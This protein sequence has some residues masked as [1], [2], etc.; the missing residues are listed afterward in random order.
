MMT[1]WLVLKIGLSSA[2]TSRPSTP[3]SGPRWSI[4]GRSMA[5]S[6][7]SGTF[8]GPG[9]CRKWR[10]AGMGHSSSRSIVHNGLR[11]LDAPPLSVKSPMTASV[12]QPV[13]FDRAGDSARRALADRLM[14]EVDAEILF[15]A[16]SRGRY[17]TDASIYQ[18][19]PLGVVVP[20][21]V[22]AAIHAMAIAV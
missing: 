13:K 6:T 5:R 12:K 10:P 21:S 18:V 9:I 19:M 1:G 11:S 20:R 15:D 4:V 2:R 17:S 16:P 7:R 22:D 3:N 8:V 14:R